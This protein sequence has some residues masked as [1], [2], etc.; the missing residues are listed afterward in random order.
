MLT[1]HSTATPNEL[2]KWK[3]FHKA[4]Q[5][6]SI[7]KNLAEPINCRTQIFYDRQQP[8][9]LIASRSILAHT[10]TKYHLSTQSENRP[11]RI[12]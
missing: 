2:K 1:H 6:L 7:S 9:A 3:F 11:R 8:L 5:H 10:K 12:T 4:E